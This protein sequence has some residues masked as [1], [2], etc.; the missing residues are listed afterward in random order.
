M[1]IIKLQ[2]NYYFFFLNIETENVAKSK[3]LL[4]NFYRAPPGPP[5]NFDTL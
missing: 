1:Y 2:C 5:K 4:V 3:P